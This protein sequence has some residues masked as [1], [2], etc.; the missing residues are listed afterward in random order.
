MPRKRGTARRVRS[1]TCSETGVPAMLRSFIRLLVAA[2][3]AVPLALSLTAPAGAT[4]FSVTDVGDDG[5]VAGTLRWA[6]AQADADATAP[7]I[8]IAPGLAIDLTCAG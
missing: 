6:V 8:D 5:T 1:I 2:V 3:V 7:V 4:A